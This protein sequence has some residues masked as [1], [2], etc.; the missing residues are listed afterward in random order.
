MNETPHVSAALGRLGA[1]FRGLIGVELTDTD[2]AELAG[3]DDDECR[4]LLRVLEET[5]EIE[6]RRS[7]VFVCRPSSWPTSTE[8]RS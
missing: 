4:I 5:G 1:I 7:R 6:R 3:L 8:V 2:V